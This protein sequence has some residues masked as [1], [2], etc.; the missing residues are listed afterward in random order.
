MALTAVVDTST[1]V[2]AFL[3]DESATADAQEL[4]RLAAVG[5]CRLTT[6]SHAMLETT[7][8]LHKAVRRDRLPRAAAVQMAA[9]L[10]SLPV[11]RIPVTRVLRLATRIAFEQDMTVYDALFV[12]TALHLRLP[13]ITAD[14]RQG[15]LVAGLVPVLSLPEAL[16]ATRET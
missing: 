10:P 12:A 9:L 2:P 3:T 7:A 11:E 15:Q 16:A 8:A 1:I 5:G 4:L 13:L 14:H 6:S